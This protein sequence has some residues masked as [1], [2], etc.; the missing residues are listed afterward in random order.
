M[1]LLQRAL[2]Q[3]I[4]ADRHYR[5]GFL[6]IQAGL[7]CPLPSNP[8]FDLAANSNTLATVAKKRFVAAFDPLA[9]E[10]DRPTWSAG[11]F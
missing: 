6:E 11:D 7:H 3:S 1:T 5:D 9:R 2:Q 10:R 4:E 8:S